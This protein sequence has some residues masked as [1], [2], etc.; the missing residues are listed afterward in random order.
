[1]RV[2]GG[3]ERAGM[4]AGEEACWQASARW[5]RRLPCPAPPA[6]HLAV[7]F[8]E[9]AAR[10]VPACGVVGAAAWRAAGW[11]RHSGAA[12]RCVQACTCCEI[13]SGPGHART[14][15]CRRQLAGRRVQGDGLTPAAAHGIIMH[16]GWGRVGGGAV[17]SVGGV[18][19]CG[20]G[21]WWIRVQGGRARS[22]APAAWPQ[23]GLP[24]RPPARPPAR[25]S[26][27]RSSI[28]SSVRM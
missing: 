11:R 26:F 14:S 6:G 8:P 24:A 25:T 15:R 10:H 21:R 19:V 22:A 12:A 13:G 9:V 17:G 28:H 16:C 2:G 3:S 27:M 1:M 18:C 5:G 7:V 23:T 4:Q 20:G